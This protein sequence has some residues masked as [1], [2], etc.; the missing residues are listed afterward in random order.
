M[1]K[2]KGFLDTVLS[3]VRM[4]DDDFFEEGFD[5]EDD[6]ELEDDDDE[7]GFIDHGPRSRPRFPFSFGGKKAN[8]SKKYNRRQVDDL[9]EEDPEYEDDYPEEP[10]D[11]ESYQEEP[12]VEEEPPKKSA[13]P[14]YTSSRSQQKKTTGKVTPMRRTHT[15]S[16]TVGEVRV[17]H[18]QDMEQ[19]LS[20]GQGLRDE[21][22]LIINL[23]GLDLEMAQRIMDFAF[24]CSYALDANVH[25]VTEYFFVI[26]PANVEISGDMKRIMK[27]APPSM[28]AEY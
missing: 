24:G 18:P 20:I 9:D 12:P 1:A 25:K 2:G 5:E 7:G 8:S 15:S 10:D 16:Q 22:V 26:A 27:G 3:G 28:N 21:A 14:T 13:K 4:N 11:Y 17:L 6:E 23:E 19:S